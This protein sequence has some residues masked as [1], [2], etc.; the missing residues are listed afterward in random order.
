MSVRMRHT[1]AHTGNRRGHHFLKTPPLSQCNHC[2]AWHVRHKA[3]LNCGYYRGRQVI[4]ISKKMEKIQA[5]KQAQAEKQ[6]EE[7]ANERPE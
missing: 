2:R 3:C 4:D 7:S 6:N 1:R 5:K